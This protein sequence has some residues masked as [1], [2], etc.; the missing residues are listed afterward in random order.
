MQE[1]VRRPLFLI[2]VVAG[3]YVAG[4]FLRN[5][6]GIELD[7][8]SVREFVLG[9][10][11][12]APLLF[13]FLVTFRAFLGLPSQV[14]LIAAGLCFGTVLGSIV[15]G[16]GLMFSGLFLFGVARY[17]GRDVI[18][19][20]LGPRVKHILDFTTR[21]SGAAALALACGYPISPLSPIH[22]AAGWTPMPIPNFMVA[23]FVGGLI[24]SAVFAYFG[25]AMTEASW[26]AL[27]APLAVLVVALAIPLLFP[28]GREWLRGLFGAPAG[29]LT[30]TLTD[31]PTDTVADTPEVTPDADPPN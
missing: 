17:A 3:V 31:T 8:T 21:R 14:V 13:V 11:P 9:L 2:A 6:L 30:G 22:A 16:A 20:R 18:E 27:L 24:R 5:E 7:A 23:A 28:A 25:D 15:G 1:S 29:T 10:G 19:K 4:T 12:L 26:G